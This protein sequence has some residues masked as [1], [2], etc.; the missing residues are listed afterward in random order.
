MVVILLMVFCFKRCLTRTALTEPLETVAPP[1]LAP[2]SAP[3][4][5]PIIR[6]E[7]A[8]I[9]QLVDHMRFEEAIMYIG[10]MDPKMGGGEKY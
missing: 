7:L 3:L 1:P 4:T 8:K 10:K 6:E 9:N 2:V 5:S